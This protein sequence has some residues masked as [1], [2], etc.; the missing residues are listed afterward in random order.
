MADATQPRLP[1]LD[2]VKAAL[3]ASF[4]NLQILALLGIFYLAIMLAATRPFWDLYTTLMTSGTSSPPEI[5]SEMF[6]LYAVLLLVIGPVGY[7]IGVIWLRVVALGREAVFDGAAPA[8]FR[9]LLMVFWRTLCYLGLTLA[10]LLPVVLLGGLLAALFGGSQ[11]T[12]ATVTMTL[13]S[14]WLV[15]FFLLTIGYA[16]SAVATSMDGN[17]G[18]LAA[19]RLIRGNWVAAGFVF[20][21]LYMPV[22]LASIIISLASLLAAQGGPLVM[23]GF[24]VLQLALSFV[25]Y[26]IAG[27]AAIL[28]YRFVASQQVTP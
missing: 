23:G 7:G 21:L 17:L 19:L 15:L 12:V 5:G 24:V 16:L 27:A 9:R 18:V 25:F 13:I 8:F 11:A 4:A 26:G 1:V 14:F 10:S 28:I 22:F 6:K 3:A 2:I 20:I